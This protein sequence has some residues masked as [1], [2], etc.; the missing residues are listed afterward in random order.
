VLTGVGAVLLLPASLAIIRVV[1]PEARER[2]RALGI[3]AACNELAFAVAPTLGGLMIER[4]GW[5][6]IFLV[7]VP[8]GLAALLLAPLA[9]PESRDDQRRHFDPAA[10][11][12]GTLALLAFTIA[13]IRLPAAPGLA[14]ALFAVA[15]LALIGF[16]TVERAIGATALVPLDLFRLREFR[17][18]G[19]ATAAMTFGMYGTLFLLPLQWPASCA[20]AADEAGL[21]LMPMALIFVALSPFSGALMGRFGVRFMAAGGVAVIGAGL[22]VIAASAQ[23]SG[24][25][26]SEVGL[27]LTGLGMGLVTGPLMGEAIGAVDAQRS[28]TAAALINVARMVGATTGVAVLGALYAMAGGGAEGLR[29]ALLTGG[30]VQIGGSAYARAR[31]RPPVRGLALKRRRST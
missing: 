21:A 24:G 9:I 30:L 29:I 5:R 26:A 4:F 28:E 16:V 3:W 2:G 8:L 19:V 25:V 15:V 7:A 20:L 13:A 10:Q 23:R 18:A 27:M 1:W 12:F 31:L 22:L 14:A 11:L 6:S 17:A